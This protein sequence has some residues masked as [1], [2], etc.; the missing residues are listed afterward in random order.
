[1]HAIVSLVALPMPGVP[2]TGGKHLLVYEIADHG[3]GV[4]Q[5]DMEAVIGDDQSPGMTSL[6]IVYV[7]VAKTVGITVALGGV[8]LMVPLK[9]VCH[10][11]STNLMM[12]FFF[13]FFRGIQNL[14]WKTF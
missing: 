5:S 2:R 11:C 8:R 14:R 3:A 4:R 10:S 9:L 13:F 12:S 7:K 6:R 1:M